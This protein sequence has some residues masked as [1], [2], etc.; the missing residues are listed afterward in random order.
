MRKDWLVIVNPNAGSG[1]VK[2]DWLLIK[3]LLDE[4]R[5]K[6]EYFFTSQAGHGI[7]ITALKLK[8]GYHKFLVV[9]G[10][11][12][13]NEV[14]NGVFSQQ[15]V[16]TTE[17]KIAMIGVGTGNDWKKMYNIHS[18]YKE[19][20]SLLKQE[21]TIYQDIGKVKYYIN[22]RQRSRYF[23]NIA[24]IGF[25]ALVTK[26]TNKQK[27]KGRSGKVLYFYNILS[28]LFGYSH[29]NVHINLDD[30]KVL[31]KAFSMNVGICKYSGGGMIQVPNA[32]PD[33]GYFDI[34]LIHKMNKIKLIRS[35]SR[36]YDGSILQHPKVSGYRSR[37]IEIDSDKNIELEVDGEYLGNGPFKFSLIP[38]SVGIIVSKEMYLEKCGQN[39]IQAQA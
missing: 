6:Y 13:L 24:G 2:R 15:F 39:L 9:G 36:L 38:Q 28:N 25:D 5:I 17:V 8:N 7:D 31:A 14:I 11:G 16:P 37:Q 27:D 12:T 26:K 29:N 34:T 10:D 21:N 30:E 32:V 4:E 19:C 18:D 20:I 22:D 3:S 23:M 35:L 33:D 1:K